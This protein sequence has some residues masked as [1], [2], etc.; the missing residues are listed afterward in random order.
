MGEQRGSACGGSASQFGSCRT[1][2]WEH[3][4]PGEHWQ[5]WKHAW[6]EALVLLGQE[7]TA[8]M[9]LFTGTAVCYDA[10]KD[11]LTIKFPAENE[12]AFKAVHKPEVREAVAVA[13]RGVFGDDLAF[14]YV[15][16]V[17]FTEVR[18]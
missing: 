10:I 11:V 14:D 1:D 5:G 13:L 2:E 17:P 18:A 4:H 16:R 3:T 12:F 15:Q 7:K 8:Y 6:E 9:V